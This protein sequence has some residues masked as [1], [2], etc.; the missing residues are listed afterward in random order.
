MVELV[1]KI[2]GPGVRW[3]LAQALVPPP[4]SC[5]ASGIY[6][7]PGVLICKRGANLVVGGCGLHEMMH[8]KV[9]TKVLL[10]MPSNYGL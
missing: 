6:V 4:A 7:S 8:V 2:T 9:L 10:T 1:V 5:G 3:T